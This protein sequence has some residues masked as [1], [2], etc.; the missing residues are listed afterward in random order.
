MVKL[1]TE[2]VWESFKE[3]WEDVVEQLEV[4]K[5]E[6]IIQLIEEKTIELIIKDAG[7]ERHE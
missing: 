6:K 4:S 3:K 5:K 7:R 2:D 1:Y